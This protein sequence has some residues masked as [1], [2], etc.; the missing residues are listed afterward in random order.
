MTGT[1]TNKESY[2]QTIAREFIG[3]RGAPLYLSPKDVALIEHWEKAGIPLD[4]IL[5]GMTRAVANFRK[6]GRPVKG[7]TLASCEYQI[8][9]AF[10][11]HSERKAGGTRKVVTRDEKGKRL[12]REVARFIAAV[13]RGLEALEP[14][15]VRAAG[16]LA[17]PEPDEDALEA[18]DEAV[19]EALV[20]AASDEDKDLV[21]TE[22]R[23]EFAGRRGLDLKGIERTKL[24]KALRDRHK[25]PY[26]SLFYY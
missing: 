4:A 6:G 3:R 8:M 1:R 21:R 14:K 26:L 25:V 24:V 13:P 18:L 10:A 23:G 22:V 16:I 2:Y 11:Q 9:K 5:E 12:A 20:R 15:F 19:D 17:L 7:L